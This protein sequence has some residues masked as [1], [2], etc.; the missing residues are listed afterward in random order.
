[1]FYFLSENV[2]K[3]EHLSPRCQGVISEPLNLGVTL[4]GEKSLAGRPQ[5][6]RGRAATDLYLT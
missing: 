5:A 6:T 2:I 4:T 3:A 1:M